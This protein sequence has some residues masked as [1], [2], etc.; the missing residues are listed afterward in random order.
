MAVTAPLSNW[1]TAAGVL[2]VGT[3]LL[4]LANWYRV[5]F[6]RQRRKWRRTEWIRAWRDRM[7]A[8]PDQPF[9]LGLLTATERSR[10]IGRNGLTSEQWFYAVSADVHNG[11]RERMPTCSDYLHEFGRRPKIRPA[12][13]M[14]TPPVENMDRLRFIRTS[15]RK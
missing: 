2:A 3:G 1:G 8:M 13:N 5:E 6:L 7:T 14:Q 10:L 12:A 9:Y 11:R 15:I 4:L